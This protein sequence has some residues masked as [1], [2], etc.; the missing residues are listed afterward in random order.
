MLGQDACR[1]VSFLFLQFGP[2]WIGL[3]FDDAFFGAFDLLDLQL[4]HLVHIRLRPFLGSEG[5][6]VVKDDVPSPRD[7]LVRELAL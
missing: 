5:W 3:E 4:G 1:N 7:G 2:P 6:N